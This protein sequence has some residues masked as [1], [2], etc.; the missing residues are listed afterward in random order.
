M[1]LLLA[2]AQVGCSQGYQESSESPGSYAYVTWNE[3]HG[4][5]EHPIDVNPETFEV[6]DS[7]EHA[8]DDVHA[9][10][11]GQVIDGADI[12][13]FVALSDVYSKDVR[14]VWWRREPLLGAD[15]ETFKV[16][17]EWWGRD[18]GDYFHRS[19]PVNACDAESFTLLTDRWQR[20]AK[21]AYLR[22]DRI[23]GADGATFVV[24]SRNFAKDHSRVYVASGF[25]KAVEGADPETFEALRKYSFMGK[26]KYRCYRF[27]EAAPCPAAP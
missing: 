11:Q 5:V 17:D 24:V 15:P 22:G 7:E 26:D 20:D 14:H 9:F 6:L 12:K 16:V 25:G 18:S 4:R 1:V 3:G 23:P 13:T 19:S 27:A 2:L 10:Y 21:C 8:K